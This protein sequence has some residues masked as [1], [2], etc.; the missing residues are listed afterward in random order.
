MNILSQAKSN[1]DEMNHCTGRQKVS[2]GVRDALGMKIKNKESV[3]KHSDTVNSSNNI[4]S[5]SNN[6]EIVN[7]NEKMPSGL[8]KW[9]QKV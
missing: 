9:M 4:N 5:E 1:S 8:D 7:R 6:S 2:K 3:T